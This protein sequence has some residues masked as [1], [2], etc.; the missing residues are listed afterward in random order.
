MVYVFTEDSRSGRD[1]WEQV[2]KAFDIKILVNPNVPKGASIGID[3]LTQLVESLT[4]N[5][6]KDLYGEPIILDK[7]DNVV[8]LYDKLGDSRSVGLIDTM[9]EDWQPPCRLYQC[10]VLCMEWLVLIFSR[11]SHW[12]APDKRSECLI[13]QDVLQD[14]LKGKIDI[15]AFWD[16]ALKNCDS[17]MQQVYRSI[18]GSDTLE[19]NP[20]GTLE[21]ALAEL[22]SRVTKKFRIL[23]NK[24]ILGPML[25][26]RLL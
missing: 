6:L 3:V 25:V 5:E 9:L 18:A 12:I 8:I 21:I 13:V 11:L 24:V 16:K 15:S 4:C 1:F 7:E 2:F 14:I 26:G 23:G 19:K 20:Y 22:L 17:R 10:K